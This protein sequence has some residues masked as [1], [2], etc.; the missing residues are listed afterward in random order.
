VT[1]WNRHT[2]VKVIRRS[3]IHRVPGKGG[4]KFSDQY[5]TLPGN[6]GKF[7]SL[8]RFTGLPF[9]MRDIAANREKVCPYCFFGGPDKHPSDQYVS[10]YDLTG[11]FSQNSANL[12]A[13]S[14]STRWTEGSK[15]QVADRRDPAARLCR[16]LRRPG[17]ARRAMA[18]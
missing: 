18:V 6:P 16:Q 9:E 5:L 14:G 13:F 10:K 1:Y 12:R 17:Q 7:I 2:Q 3:K 15:C 4:C 8:H 11:A